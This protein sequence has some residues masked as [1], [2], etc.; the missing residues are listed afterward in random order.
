MTIESYDIDNIKVLPLL[1]QTGYLTIKEINK[2]A[3]GQ[4]VYV[5]GYPNQEVKQ[6][7]LANLMESYTV[8]PNEQTM[9]R[10]RELLDR[11]TE[12]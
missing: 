1:L 6:S 2:N 5:L 7:M 12:R 8:T 3:I 10:T 4:P 9:E 11:L